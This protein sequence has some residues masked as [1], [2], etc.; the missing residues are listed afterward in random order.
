MEDLAAGGE[1]GLGPGGRG[2][3]SGEV[4]DQDLAVPLH[5]VPE[6]ANQA[7]PSGAPATV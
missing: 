5:Q 4:V 3:H 6:V 7:H 1:L 2:V